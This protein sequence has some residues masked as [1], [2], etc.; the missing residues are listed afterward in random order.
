ML[1]KFISADMVYIGGGVFTSKRNVEFMEIAKR[2]GLEPE[3]FR[4]LAEFIAAVE[5]LRNPPPD[6]RS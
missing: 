1:G 4:T 5:R 2:H 6:A 3:Q